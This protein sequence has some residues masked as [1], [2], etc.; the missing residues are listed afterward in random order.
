MSETPSWL[1]GLVGN[2]RCAACGRLY[3]RED[4][5]PVGQRDAHWSVWCTCGSCGS[6]GIAVVIV[7]AASVPQPSAAR[8]DRP[9]ITADDVLSA[10]EVLRDYAGNVDGLFGAGSSRT[11]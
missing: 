11:R 8:P 10:H 5:R 3:R 9:V 1:E 2:V 4:L 7:Q 6:R